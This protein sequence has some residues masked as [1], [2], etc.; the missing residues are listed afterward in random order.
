MQ[1]PR[2]QLYSW[3]TALDAWNGY[4]AVPLDEDS[5]DLTTF[6]TPWE[7]YRYT[8]APQGY[9]ASGDAYTRRSDDIT[10]K[11]TG[12]MAH[13]CKVIDDTLLYSE[14]IEENFY[15][16]WAYL[17]LC[18]DNGITF[19]VSKFQFC[20]REIEFAGFRVGE[21]SVKPSKEILNRIR[22]FTAPTNLKESRGWFDHATYGRW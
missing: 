11:E 4:H 2:V 15:K 10:A 12:L 9:I 21:D 3:K 5:K 14:S 7:K 20:K 6:I 13:S 16:T 17:K 18:A 19:N 1:V 8:R 22:D